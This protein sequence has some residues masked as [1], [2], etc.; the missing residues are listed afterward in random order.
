MGVRELPPI[1]KREPLEVHSVVIEVSTFHAHL[2]PALFDL[3]RR[4]AVLAGF[5]DVNSMSVSLK[6][7]V[8]GPNT[9]DQDYGALYDRIDKMWL[10]AHCYPAE[11]EAR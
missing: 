8:S 6:L 3:L 1:S 2:I 7:E 9:T 5:V 10:G 4:E 11:R